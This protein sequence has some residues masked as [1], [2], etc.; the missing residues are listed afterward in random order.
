MKI[1]I[2][3]EKRH[4][5]FL[6]VLVSVL[7]VGGVGAFG[8]VNPVVFGH[9]D[10][11][12]ANV[13]AQKIIAGTFG[14]NAGNG[15]YSFPNNL[16]ISGNLFFSNDQKGIFWASS[17]DNT[18]PYLYVDKT[19]V[20]KGFWISSGVGSNKP[21]YIQ[22]GNLSIQNGSITFANNATITAPKNLT[23]NTPNLTITK[24]LTLGGESKD[25]WP[26]NIKNLSAENISSGI[27]GAKVGN[28][29]YTFPENLNVTKNLIIGGN[30]TFTNNK[31]QITA[32]TNLLLN[33]SNVTV[34][35]NLTLNG[36]SRD[37]WPTDF[38]SKFCVFSPTQSF[39]PTG[40]TK[41]SAFDGST[42]QGTTGNPGITGGSNTHTHTMAYWYVSADVHPSGGEGGS[43]VS[44][45]DGISASATSSWPPYVN[46]TICCKN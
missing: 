35:G 33:T 3:I 5:I 6:V 8:T 26:S 14:Q 18:Q 36:T 21:I 38:P 39:C 10:G 24:N 9:S 34:Q 46:V 45:D 20:Q 28:G 37:S 31:A 15:S 29:D 12:I 43:V 22:G 32:Q 41:S 7:F 1:E 23:I 17:A 40:W 11:E 30:I 19:T 16:S 42:I 2:N 27:F 4:F 13:S 25:K 44:Y